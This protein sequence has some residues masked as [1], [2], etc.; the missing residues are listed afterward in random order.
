VKRLI[1]IVLVAW[2]SVA[3]A[4]LGCL[5]EERDLA[6]RAKAVVV[7]KI[8]KVGKVKVAPCPESKPPEVHELTLGRTYESGYA[9]CGEV[10]TL[11]AVVVESLRGELSGKIDVL[12]A[13]QTGLSPGPCDD[14]PELPKMTG[15]QAILYL[16]RDGS[17][18]WTLDGPD[19]IY[20]LEPRQTLSHEFIV[21]VKQ[22]LSEIPAK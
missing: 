16:Q 6:N 20:T 8:V 1:A 11:E 19:S 18:W 9:N 5:T 17:R 14:R 10:G 3:L 4:I 13:R 21:R 12:V 7:V 15:L 22:L 2:P